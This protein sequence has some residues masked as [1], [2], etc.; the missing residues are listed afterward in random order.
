[1]LSKNLVILA[2]KS[3]FMANNRTIFVSLQHKKT[4]SYQE[5]V[6]YQETVIFFSTP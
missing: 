1:M 3:H 2:N 6:S 5:I 4:V